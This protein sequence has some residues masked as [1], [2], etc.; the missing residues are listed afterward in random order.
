MTSIP[1]PPLDP[2]AVR[3]FEYV[4]EETPQVPIAIYE[5]IGRGRSKLFLDIYNCN[6]PDLYEKPVVVVNGVRVH[7]PDPELVSTNNYP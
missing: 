6:P 3:S 5:F 2:V 7:L 4:S 1:L